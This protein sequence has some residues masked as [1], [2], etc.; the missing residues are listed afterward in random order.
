MKTRRAILAAAA[1]AALLSALPAPAYYHF[2]HYLSTGRAPAKFDLSALP[3]NTVWFFV[4]ETGP[5]AYSVNDNF[6]SVVSQ[7]RQATQVWNNV[8]TSALR[9]GFGGFENATT[10][11]NTPAA[12]VIFEDLAP[13]LL[14]YGSITTSGSVI[15]PAGGGVTADA[16]NH[17]TPA[18]TSASTANAP[19]VPITRSAIYLNSN[20]VL[21]PSYSETFFT[22]IV[23][24]MGHALGLQHTFTSSA[25]STATTR[26]TSHANPIELDDEAGISALYPNA[27]FAQTGSI[28]G[29][30][31]SGGNAVSMESVVAIS[32][33]G[34]AISALT[35][36]DGT[37]EI[38][39]I[40]QG[41]YFVYAHALP[42]DADIKGPWNVDGS[43]AAASGPTNALFYPGTTDL[44][45]ATPVNVKAGALV[46]NINIAV[47]SLA[48]LPVYDVAV[49]GYYA[50]NT[51]AVKPAYLNMLGR[52]STVAASGVGLGVNGEAPGLTAAFMGSSAIVTTGGV[53][54][55]QSGANTYV[56]LDVV[57]FQFGAPGPQHL[58]FNSSGF[59]HVLPSA[60][61]LTLQDPPTIQ[62]VTPNSDGSLTVTGTNWSSGSA[63][64]FDGLPGTLASLNASASTAVVIPPPG[65]S[66]QTAI[67]TVYNPDG[68]NSEFEQL[69]NPA[70]YTYA[71]SA[72]QTIT[73]I[74][75]AAL[76]AGAEAMIDIQGTGFNFVQGQ[77][78]VGFG[79]SD[80]SIRQIYVLGPNHLRVDV[81]VAAGAALSSP[82]VSVFSGFQMATATAAFHITA[83]LS[84]LPAP[85]PTLTNALPGLTNSYAGAVV[86]LY[87][88]NLAAQ[89]G[90]VS[91]AINGEAAPILYSSPTQINLQ[92]PSDIATGSAVLQLYN[93]A[94]SAYPV[95]VTIDS[96]PAAVTGIVDYAGNAIGASNPAAQGSLL[97]VSLS[98]FA[99][100]GSA[101]DASRVQ[102]GV[103]GVSRSVLSVSQSAPGG[104]QVS[105]LLGPAES[106]GPAQQ[107][108]VYLDGR[109]SYPAAIPV[110]ASSTTG[111]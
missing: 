69:A 12:D 53:R 5:T 42:P 14:G 82:D 87:G 51:V 92:I 54:P 26:A 33:N 99:P 70:T 47:T 89:T 109:S 67:L 45:Q 83:A 2:V 15:T 96:P 13:G 36:P 28:S 85:I 107:L 94:A 9:V 30:I 38:D 34:A 75:P 32:T 55:Y 25:M 66:G 65:L 52:E 93:G 4:S 49:Y 76:P 50:N 68:Q 84:G 56:A 31:L 108:V 57:Y 104:Y 22:T 23:H 40:P 110:I 95:A 64:Y 63:I 10:P 100:D 105:F 7:L 35:N 98:G 77:T 1:A 11:Q 3:N 91:V 37:F 24:E 80:V 101:I 20:Q 90:V 61:R 79:T 6:S 74:S 60:I 71:K 8:S 27:A 19:W 29:Q 18:A 17:A 59:M 102:A 41:Q 106:T 111:N 62:S 16:R 81:S 46:P 43:V 48:T 39:G 78:T 44:L 72:A 103:G 88:S 58:I 21:T 97:T 86:S 73:S